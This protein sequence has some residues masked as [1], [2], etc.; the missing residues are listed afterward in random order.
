MT[1]RVCD[2]SHR[3]K[4]VVIGP[5]IDRRIFP[6]KGRARWHE[7]AWYAGLSHDE[8]H[9]YNLSGDLNPV[10]LPA[11]AVDMTDAWTL[12][13]VYGNNAKNLMDRLVTI[14][15]DPF[16]KQEPC[17]FATR[18]HNAKVYILNMKNN[19]GFLIACDRSFGH[20][21]YEMCFNAPGFLGIQPSV[22][23]DFHVWLKSG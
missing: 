7:D 13:A 21:L 11:C 5:D 23:R 14:D 6:G 19:K 10:C 18:V 12:M 2:L 17:F 9:Y 4:A 16:L 22:E 20:G 8:G 15:I 3:P 1:I